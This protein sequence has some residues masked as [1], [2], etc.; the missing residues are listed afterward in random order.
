[1]LYVTDKFHSRGHVDPWCLDNCGPGV[2]E[3]SEAIDAMNTS[4]CEITFA[5]LARFKH[6]TRKMK[7]WAFWFFIQE[8]IYCRNADLLRKTG[9][10]LSVDADV[11]PAEGPS[12]VS[13]SSA[14][15]SSSTASSHSASSELV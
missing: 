6:M 12:S 15:S 11:R 5:W 1:M 8:V 10:H 9:A 4:I 13:S 2:P 14:A 7:Q 3:N